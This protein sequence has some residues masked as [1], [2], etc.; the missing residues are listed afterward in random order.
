MDLRRLEELD[1]SKPVKVETDDQM[2][3]A[4]KKHQ[5]H[6]SEQGNY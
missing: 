3:A 2:W 1:T 6:K 5:G 4:V